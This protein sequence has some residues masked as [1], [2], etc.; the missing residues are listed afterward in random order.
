VI[1]GFLPTDQILKAFNLNASISEG[2]ITV[3]MAELPLVKQELCAAF[4][5]AS[6]YFMNELSKEMK[7]TGNFHPLNLL[8]RIIENEERNDIGGHIQVAIAN[9]S[10][11]MLPHVVTERLDRGEF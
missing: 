11:V 7:L 8:K 4:G 10:G 6:T 2:A 9:S 3:T 1:F 5:S